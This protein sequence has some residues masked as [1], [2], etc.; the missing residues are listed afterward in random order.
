MYTF[1]SAFGWKF[2]DETLSEKI[3][4]ENEF[5]KIDPRNRSCPEGTRNR[6]SSPGMPSGARE[7]W[8]SRSGHASVAGYGFLVRIG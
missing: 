6:W 2:E 4:A 5:C 8:L 1:V 3:P 7:Q